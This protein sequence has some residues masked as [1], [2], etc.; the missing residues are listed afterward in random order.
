[1]RQVL[2]TLMQGSSLPSFSF[3]VLSCAFQNV[4]CCKSCFCNIAKTNR[5]V[6]AQSAKRPLLIQ[7]QAHKRGYLVPICVAKL[8]SGST[9]ELTVDNVVLACVCACVCMCVCVHACIHVCLH[10]ALT[11]SVPTCHPHLSKHRPLAHTQIH[12]Y[13]TKMAC[14]S[15]SFRARR[16]PPS[17]LMRAFLMH[18]MMTLRSQCWRGVPDPWTHSCRMYRGL[19]VSYSNW[20]GTRGQVADSRSVAIATSRAVLRSCCFWA[21]LS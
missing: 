10:H 7:T 17:E 15:F 20:L 21:L 4:V 2:T 9:I 5:T 1:M 6:V 13:L 12:T 18:S 14:I 8:A 16:C 19:P 11:K 3:F